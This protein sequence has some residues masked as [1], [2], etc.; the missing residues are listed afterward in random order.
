MKHVL[1]GVL[2]GVVAMLPVFVLVACVAIMV[3]LK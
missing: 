3:Y 2:I 1:A